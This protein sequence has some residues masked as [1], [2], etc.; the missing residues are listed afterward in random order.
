ML[1]GLSA[2]HPAQPTP[3]DPGRDRGRGRPRGQGHSLVDTVCSSDDPQGGDDRPPAQVVPLELE[4]DLPGPLC[5]RGQVPAHDAWAVSCS[6][7]T[8][9]GGR[10]RAGQAHRLSWGKWSHHP[11]LLLPTLWPP[12]RAHRGSHRSTA[13]RTAPDPTKG[14]SAFCQE[15]GAAALGRGPQQPCVRKEGAAVSQAP[16]LYAGTSGLSTAKKSPRAVSALDR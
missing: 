13:R 3:P 16:R 8:H 6:Q 5:Q 4:A 7:T 9:C 11:D 2:Y 10:E 1:T 15:Q 14:S 12:P